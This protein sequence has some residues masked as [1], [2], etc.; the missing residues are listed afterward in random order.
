MIGVRTGII[1]GN[2]HYGNTLGIKL[3]DVPVIIGI[4]WMILIYCVGCIFHKIPGPIAVKSLMGAALLT[5]LDLMMEPIAM[6]Y[7]FW[8]WNNS[9]IPAQ[10]Y[11]AWFVVSFLLLL[12]FH[13]LK[14]NKENKLAPSFYIIQ[15]AFFGAF[16][17]YSFTY[18]FLK[19]K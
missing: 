18:N 1:F 17:T 3:L 4:N 10:N 7:D 5:G 9:P 15:L 14:F 6:K 19:L 2:Y 12:I 16:R 11:V 13:S 8:K